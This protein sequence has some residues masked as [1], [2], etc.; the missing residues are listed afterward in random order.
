MSSSSETSCYTVVFEDSSE[1]PSTQEL[2]ASLEKGTDEVKIDTLRRIIIATSNGNPQVCSAFLIVEGLECL[3][4]TFISPHYWCQSYNK[5]CR[6][7]TNSLRNCYISTGKYVRS[8]T[9][10][11]NSSRRWSWSCGFSTTTHRYAISYWLC[12]CSNAI[13]N[14]LVS[15]V[16]TPQSSLCSRSPPSNI[17]TNISTA[18]PS[19][20]FKKYLKTLNCSNRSSQ[21]PLLRPQKRRL[22]CI[23][24][25]EFENLIPDAPE[26]M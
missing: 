12:L 13:R 11:E 15:S 20:S 21:P 4:L 5:F 10:M 19:V 23:Y 2:K 14:D 3:Q 7:K 26:L 18:Q 22:R 24:Y 16:I 6:L 25:R 8:S 9:R 17:Q 1:S